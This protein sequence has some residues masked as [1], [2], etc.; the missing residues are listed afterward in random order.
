MVSSW[1]TNARPGEGQQMLK[2]K[3]FRRLDPTTFT[4]TAH[5]GPRPLA[6]GQL[7]TFPVSLQVHPGDFIGLNSANAA[8]VSNACFYPTSQNGDVYG[9]TGDLS[10]G[11]NGTFAGGPVMARI[12]VS[13]VV[14][15]SNQVTLGRLIRNIRKGTATEKVVVPNPGFLSISGN[16]VRKSAIGSVRPIVVTSAGTIKVPIRAKGK[17]LKRLNAKGAVKVAPTITFTPTDGTPRSVALR[18]KLLK[19]T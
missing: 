11:D 13:A 9:R 12:N 3:V 14:E 8:E 15:P 2:F 17:K 10:D 19:K 4:A 5:D 6:P 16:G 18:V 7:N 1:S